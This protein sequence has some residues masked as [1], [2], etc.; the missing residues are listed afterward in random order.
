[1]AVSF[2]PLTPGG[3]SS[4]IG[5]TTS[6]DPS[7]ISGSNQAQSLAESQANTPYSSLP[8]NEAVAPMSGNQ[9]LGYNAAQNNAG[10]L[11]GDYNTINSSWTN[12]STQAQYMSPYENS[13]LNAQKAYASQQQGAQ[14]AA[15]GVSEGMNNSFGGSGGAIA[16]AQELQ[17]YNLNSNSMEATGLQSAYT[18]GQQQFNT[19]QGEALSAANQ[20]QGALAQTGSVAQQIAQAGDTYNVTNQQNAL[21]WSG[22]QAQMLSGVLNSM[23]KN[24]A[25]TRDTNATTSASGISNLG[26]VGSLI[27]M[28]MNLAGGGSGSGGS[29]SGGNATNS[30]GTTQTQYDATEPTASQVNSNT[31]Y[32][33]GSYSGSTGN[34]GTANWGTSTGDNNGDLGS[35]SSSTDYTPTGDEQVRAGSQGYVDPGANTSGNALYGGALGSNSM[36]NPTGGMALAGQ[37]LG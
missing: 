8:T 25:S 29:G 27:G 14:T 12:P 20:E 6:Y 36:T 1:V 16:Q 15:L 28:G 2:N 34:N 21:N 5:A 35:G 30:D 26:G 33:P 18:A 31:T 9:T 17:N 23:P 11:Q 24:S 10:S 13:V 19:A 37:D 22:K 32:V 4:T 3:S 7:V